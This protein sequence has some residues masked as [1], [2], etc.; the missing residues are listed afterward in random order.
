VLHHQSDFLI[1]D[2]EGEPAVSLEER[3]AKQSALRDVAG[4]IYSFFYAASAVLRD[5]PEKQI[6][7]LN[8]ANA[9]RYWSVWV[10]ASFLKA[11]RET[12]QAAS[13][14]PADELALKNV[15]DL[16]LLRKAI[17]EL[18]Y[19]LNNRPAWV[20]IAFNVLLDL[21]DPENPL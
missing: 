14:L 8:R 1:I 3:R 16:E 17:Y 10:G 15:L 9:A 12:A 21:L 13:F 4:M 11:Y 20:N 7:M 18:G 2:F 19:E 5:L 6:R